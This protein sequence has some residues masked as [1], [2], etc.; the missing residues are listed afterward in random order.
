MRAGVRYRIVASVCLMLLGKLSGDVAVAEDAIKLPKPHYEGEQS[1]E[2]LLR[3]RRSIREFSDKPVTLGQ[4]SQL[5]W[6]AQGVTTRSG[7]RTAPSAGAL[8]PLEL[9]VVAGAVSGLEPGSYH[10]NIAKH[11]LT[12]VAEGDR[13]G[14]LAAAAFGQH[15]VRDA[16]AV[17]VIGAVYDRTAVKYG[18]RARRY[19]HMEAG[20]A[21]QNV[22]LQATALG[23]GATPI[24]AFGDAYV[25]EVAEMEWTH[26]PLYLLPVGWPAGG[27]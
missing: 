18:R 26:E 22:L 9:Y 15:V 7:L 23:L 3:E 21:G 1:L 25:R 2:E 24:G 17:V 6:A 27:D 10:Y 4:L 14:E 19:V 13:R 16:A 8:Y 5:L 12:R 11:T 20:H